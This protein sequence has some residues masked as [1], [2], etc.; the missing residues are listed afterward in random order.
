MQQRHGWSEQE[1]LDPVV[2]IEM[3]DF[4]KNGERR[5]VYH[6]RILAILLVLIVSARIE[7]ADEVRP[8]HLVA[9]C[10]IFGHYFVDVVRCVAVVGCFRVFELFQEFLVLIALPF[11]AIVPAFTILKPVRLIRVQIEAS[12]RDVEVFID[13]PVQLLVK[14]ELIPFAGLR[15]SVVC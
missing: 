14:D 8:F 6:Y 4:G 15:K 3:N 5:V 11:C 1:E 12:D 10:Y 2:Y 13:Q 9:V 7:R